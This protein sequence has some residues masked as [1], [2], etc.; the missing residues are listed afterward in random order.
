MTLDRFLSMSQEERKVWLESS[1]HRYDC[2][3]YSEGQVCCL[4]KLVEE[5]LKK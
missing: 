1:S 4:D 5:K 2:A 3:A